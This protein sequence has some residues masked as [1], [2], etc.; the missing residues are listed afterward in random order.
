VKVLVVSAHPDDETLGCGGTLLRHR[1]QGDELVWAVTTAAYVPAWTEEVVRTKQAEKESVADAYGI[2]SPV[3]MDF[4]AA[5]LDTVPFE[6]IILSMDEII[7]KIA[8]EIVYI[9]HGGDVH[10]DH[11]IVHQA[12]LS[13]LKPPR[14]KNLG[15]KRILAYETLSSTEAGGTEEDA[16]FV[17]NLY[18]D[19]SG[20]IDQ[21][22]GIMDLYASE[23][24]ADPMPRGASAIR[25]L[26]RYRG[27]TIGVEY[28][29]AFMLIR[30]IT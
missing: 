2:T 4:P 30:E 26:A 7:G 1:D 5:R 21:K 19:I 20:Y 17:P 28:A 14:M 18:T 9:V 3:F 10:S 16:V 23:T 22:I 12:V 8:P 24:Q 25:A 13:V 11:R 15:V 27:A 29:E 6:E